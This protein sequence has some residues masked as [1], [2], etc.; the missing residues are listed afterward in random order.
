MGGSIWFVG[1][2]WN[3]YASHLVFPE[4]DE[5]SVSLNLFFFWNVPYILGCFGSERWILMMTLNSYY[6][7]FKT[8]FTMYS[9]LSSGITV[10]SHR[11]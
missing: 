11:R 2:G 4:L 6:L 7:E 5:I 10:T 3:T 9:N 1:I 8:D